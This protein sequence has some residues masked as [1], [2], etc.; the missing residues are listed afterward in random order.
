VISGIT[1]EKIMQIAL[2]LV[3]MKA[4]PQDSGIH[5]P[6]ERINKI[7]FS[8]D[9]NVGLLTMAKQLGFDAVV[10]HHPCG[11]LYHRGEVFRGHI[12]LL[13][14]HG[15]PK[16]KSLAAIGESI[17]NAVKKIENNRFRQLYYES[18]N[19]TILE[20]DAAR[21]LNMPFMNVHNMLD[22]Q[23]RRILQAKIDASAEAD[24]NW[25]LG[26]VLAMIKDLPEAR[27]AKDIYDISPYILTGDADSVAG[28][29]V[30]VHGALSAPNPDII[31]FYW[32]CGF[33]TVI[34]LH[35]DYNSLMALKKEPR[36][37]LILTGHFLGDS[38]GFPPFIAALRERGLAVSCT[39]GIIDA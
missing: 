34:I 13:E 24:P 18:P 7:L 22:E 37:N 32:E 29:T 31:K 27:Y 19:Q 25:K 3:G 2:D 39:G 4:V 36:G 1:T 9:V 16:E 35:N 12:D 38:L 28:K 11:V 20:V 5:L 23:G 10:G 17:S 14:M 15:V 30:F 6:G 8:M 21:L 33:K 26:D